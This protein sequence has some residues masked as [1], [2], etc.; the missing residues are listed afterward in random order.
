MSRF[1]FRKFK[2]SIFIFLF[3]ISFAFPLWGKKQTEDEQFPQMS[4]TPTIPFGYYHYSTYFYTQNSESTPTFTE[5]RV[6]SQSHN[7]DNENEEKFKQSQEFILNTVP[8]QITPTIPPIK[9]D[10][11]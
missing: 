9:D 4:A 7:N 8:P 5:S 11:L 10:E 3:H 6:F 1:L 2:M